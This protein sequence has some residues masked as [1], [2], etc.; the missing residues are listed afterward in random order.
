MLVTL[1][2]NQLMLKLQDQSNP[3]QTTFGLMVIGFG[4]VMQERIPME[5]VDGKLLTEGE[6]TH[7]GVGIIPREDTI[8]KTVEDV[9]K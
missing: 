6:T 3:L 7:L 4:T 9:K 1:Q 5:M 2:N 8:G